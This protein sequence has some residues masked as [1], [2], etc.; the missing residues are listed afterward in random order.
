MMDSLKTLTES[1]QQQSLINFAVLDHFGVNLKGI[2][3]LFKTENKESMLSEKTSLNSSFDT[4]NIKIKEKQNPP[5]P[6]VFCPDCKARSTW[7]GY[8]YKCDEKCHKKQYDY[9]F[10]SP[11]LLNILLF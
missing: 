7:N 6:I 11:R 1:L 10:R 3:S 4:S 5:F 9:S 2:S 8:K